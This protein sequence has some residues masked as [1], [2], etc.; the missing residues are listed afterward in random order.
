MMQLLQGSVVRQ[1]GREE[2]REG[3][4]GGLIFIPTI[5]LLSK[6]EESREG[7]R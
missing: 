5:K 1:V 4:R 3:G 6:S 7:G 2:G